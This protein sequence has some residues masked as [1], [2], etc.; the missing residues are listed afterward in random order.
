MYIKFS[1]NTS[2]L[3]YKKRNRRKKGTLREKAFTPGIIPPS[4]AGT[5]QEIAEIGK[6]GEEICGFKAYGR[7]SQRIKKCV[8]NS[9][10]FKYP[11]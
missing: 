11:A 2:C 7:Q 10:L 8:G 6:Q 3:S 5:Q 1:K 4:K 9:D